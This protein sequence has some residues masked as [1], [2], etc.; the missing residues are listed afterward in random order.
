M[1]DKL[2]DEELEKLGRQQ[3]NKYQ[4]EWYSRDENKGKRKEYQR[5]HYIK[6]GLEELEDE[7]AAK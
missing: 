6:K 1:K 3:K 7:K 2:T 5:R 4:R